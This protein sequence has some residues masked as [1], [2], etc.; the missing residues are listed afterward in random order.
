MAAVVV[1]C[2]VSV[3]ELPQLLCD[4]PV[5]VTGAEPT[6]ATATATAA[7]TSCV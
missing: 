1:L 5:S 6:A 4:K 3:S 7:A 2:V